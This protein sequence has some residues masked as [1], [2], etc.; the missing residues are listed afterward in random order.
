MLTSVLY[1]IVDSNLQGMD[2][3]ML[4]TVD[5]HDATMLP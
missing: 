2:S 3:I 4:V 1:G 5:D